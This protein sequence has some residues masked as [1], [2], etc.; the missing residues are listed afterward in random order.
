MIIADRV[1]F[2]LRTYYSGRHATAAAQFAQAAKSLEDKWR[3]REL[4]DRSKVDA[5]HS[6]FVSGSVMAS[7]AMVEATINELFSDAEENPARFSNW[8]AED[9]AALADLWK[10]IAYDGRAR[11]AGLG[12][13]KR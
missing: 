12:T 11:K 1:R 10:V 5:E 13:L 7:V 2:S 4:T 6:P 3:N 8:P 9:R